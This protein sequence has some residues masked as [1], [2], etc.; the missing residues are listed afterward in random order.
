V[1]GQDTIGNQVIVELSKMPHLLIAGST[2]SGKSVAL[3][4][5]LISMLCRLS[6]DDLKLILIDPK[7]LEFASYADIAHL[8]FPVITD[9]L[10]AT[11]ALRWVVGEMEARYEKMAACGVRTIADYRATPA[12]KSLPY[13]V[14]V[15]DELADLMMTAG[16]DC[17]ELITRITQMARAACTKGYETPCATFLLARYAGAQRRSLLTSM[18]DTQRTHRAKRCAREIQETRNISTRQI[19]TLAYKKSIVTSSSKK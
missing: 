12:G 1:L 7:R 13:I 8:L 5:M 15:I 3:N 2:G 9:A 17:Q 16:R 11:M 6:P 4:V 10:Q 14:V 19:M 18:R